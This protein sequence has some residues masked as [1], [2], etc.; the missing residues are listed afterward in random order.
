MGGLLGK[1]GSRLGDCFWRG[2]GFRL[3]LEEVFGEGNGESKL[4]LS[5]A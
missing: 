4:H 2:G 3:I 5:G 1:G